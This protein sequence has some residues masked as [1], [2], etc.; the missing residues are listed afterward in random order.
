M[1][2]TQKPI[3]PNE[4]QIIG[5][6]AVQ[7]NCQKSRIV[8]PKDADLTVIGLPRKKKYIIKPVK[9]LLKSCQEH[10]KQILSWMLTDDLVKKA[11]LG[12]TVEDKEIISDA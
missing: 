11:L 7:S 4:C 3:Y 10:N 8:R 5:D 1:K 6:D 2:S 9:F 12:Q